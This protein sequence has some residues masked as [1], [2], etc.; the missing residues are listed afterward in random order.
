MIHLNLLEPPYWIAPEI[1]NKEINLTPAV[2]I[3][4][5]GCIVIEMATTQPPWSNLSKDCSEVIEIISKSQGEF[6]F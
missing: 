5:I 1:I 2:D 3:W 4:S 6:S